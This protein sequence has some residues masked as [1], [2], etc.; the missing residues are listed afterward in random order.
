[1]TAMAFVAA[2]DLPPAQAVPAAALIPS[3]SDGWQLIDQRVLSLAS[4]DAV[5]EA[6][7][8]DM[9]II[10]VF[11]FDLT[12]HLPSFDD[13]RAQYQAQGSDL[14]KVLIYR[15]PPGFLGTGNDDYRI[16]AIHSQAA[17]LIQAVAAVIAAITPLVIAAFIL[18]HLQA[19]EMAVGQLGQT[20][21]NDWI[22]P[23][24]KPVVNEA[25]IFFGVTSAIIF[26][27]FF[28]ERGIAKRT[29]E[30]GPPLPGLP[31]IEAPRPVFGGSGGV[32]LARGPVSLSAGQT[33]GTA[34]GPSGGVRP[35]LR[36][37]R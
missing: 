34:T 36:R 25:I 30:E 19:V 23:A 18:T 26:G 33:F 16:I 24:I 3:A 10:A 2:Q 14:Y 11:G 32:T 22:A 37:R 1:M 27:L 8:I 17:V 7:A 9:R 12:G 35:N 28:L 21:G 6:E 15:N 13:L 20:F 4:P 31:S 5:V 29:G